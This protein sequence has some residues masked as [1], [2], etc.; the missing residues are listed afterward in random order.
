MRPWGRGSH[1]RLKSFASCPY[2]RF[3]D[4]GLRLREWEEPGPGHQV[5][6]LVTGNLYHQ[7]YERTFRALRD[8]GA[9][10]LTPE[11]LDDARAEA[12][13]AIEA[14]LDEAA[15]EGLVVHRDLLGPLGV[16][17]VRDLDETLLI[18]ADAGD[19]WVPVAF[20]QEFRDVRIGYGEGRE[21]VLGGI[22]DRV[23][24]AEDPPR[25]RVLDWKTGRFRFEED[26]EFEGGREFQLV[27]YNAA[28][29]SLYPERQVSEAVYRFA[30]EKGRFSEK[31]CPNSPEK[32]ETLGR[33]LEHLDALAQSGV[34]APTAD[35]CAF[36]TFL[37]ICGPHRER[38]A[39]RKAD[40]PRLAPF[41]RLREIP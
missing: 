28:A 7:A 24:F 14:V 33:I 17:M 27:L 16:D 29:E 19:G 8:K 21:V 37:E 40:D 4:T 15:A 32:R 34:F 2:R 10:P 6:H 36:C 18:E 11:A 12:R 9:L 38:R 13:R 41:R 30:T 26:A 5:D 35:S 25:V 22:L 31:A 20:E 1:T 23:D 39:A 3:L